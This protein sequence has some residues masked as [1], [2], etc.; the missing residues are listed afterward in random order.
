MI[1]MV[2]H[3]M[4]RNRY[5]VDKNLSIATDCLPAQTGM[6]AKSRREK[7]VDSRAG[8]IGMPQWGA[9]GVARV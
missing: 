3:V 4:K 9:N 8:R 6:A 5:V 2:I 1:V 7:E